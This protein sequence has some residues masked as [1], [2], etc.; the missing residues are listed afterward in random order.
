MLNQPEFKDVE[1]FKRLLNMLEEERLLYDIL[2]APSD[3]GVVVTIG[4]ENKFSGI[5]DC[6]MVR[7]TYCLGGEVVGTIA[8]LGPTRMDYAKI[9]ATLEFMNHNLSEILK[10]YKL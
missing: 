5:Q 4:R 6:S 10:H 1:K 3:D 9:M 8:V 7:A 2:E